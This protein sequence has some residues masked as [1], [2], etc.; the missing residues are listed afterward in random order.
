M[1]GDNGTI[2]GVML[3]IVEHIGSCH[4]FGVIAGHHIPHDYLVFPGEPCIL[5][6]PHPSMRRTHQIGVEVGVGF[7][8]IE[9]VI[10]DGVLESADMVMGV[11]A[12]AMTLREAHRL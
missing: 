5:A 11:I 12:D 7:L 8:Y 3:Y 10:T 2:A 1:E 9:T 4:P 6:Q